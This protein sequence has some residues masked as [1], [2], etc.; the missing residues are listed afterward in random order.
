MQLSIDINIIKSQYDEM[1]DHK[2][3][4]LISR[5]ESWSKLHGHNYIFLSKTFDSYRTIISLMNI[6]SYQYIIRFYDKECLDKWPRQ[7]FSGHQT[8]NLA[9]EITTETTSDHDENVILT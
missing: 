1:L 3:V 2:R 4:K 7:L 5:Y 9:S 6:T 8:I